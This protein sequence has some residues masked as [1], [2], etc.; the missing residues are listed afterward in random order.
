[1][2]KPLWK[3]DG[4]RRTSKFTFQKCEDISRQL[5]TVNNEIERWLRGNSNLSVGKICKAVISKTQLNFFGALLA[6]VPQTA[7][8]ICP[9]QEPRMFEIRAQMPTHLALGVS[10][11]FFQERLFDGVLSTYCSMSHFSSSIRKQSFLVV[12]SQQHALMTAICETEKIDMT[13]KS[14]SRSQQNRTTNGLNSPETPW[15][16]GWDSQKQHHTT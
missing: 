10:P 11:P 4:K 3:C 16:F 12:S 6:A 14:R 8:Q 15:A 13:R 9:N 7:H 5:W 1:M 2:W